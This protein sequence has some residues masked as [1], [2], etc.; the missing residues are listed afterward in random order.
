MGKVAFLFA[1]QG[2]QRPGMGVALAAASPAARAVFEAADSLRPR[3]FDQCRTASKEELSRTENTQPCVFAVDLAC[4]R[5]LQERGVEPD[6]A[7]GFSLGEVAALTFAGAFDDRAGFGL[8]CRR[9]ELMAQAASER[10]GAMRAVVKLEASRVEALAREA[11]AATDGDC[12]PVNYNSPLQTAVAGSPAACERLDAL[13]KEAGGRSLPVAVSGA[14]HSP[15]MASAARGLAGHL[16][17]GR[18]PRETRIPVLANSTA[19]PYPA[20]P[21]ASA[22]LLSG[23]VSSPVRWTETLLAMRAAGADTFVEVGPG[24]TLCGLV[25]RTLE[26]ARAYHVET[27]EELDEA[28]RELMAGKEAANGR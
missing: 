27:P 24:A 1:G 4:A 3:T 14:F 7:A 21:R 16:E 8:V 26:G 28:S 13:V 19:R 23:Q 20:D 17:Q 10:P 5:A 25:R 6:M 11:A 9:A 22:A 12:W 15:Y 2:A 18:L